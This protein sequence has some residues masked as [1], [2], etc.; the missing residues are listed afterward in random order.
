MEPVMNAAPTGSKAAGGNA[1]AAF[2]VSRAP[3]AAAAEAGVAGARPG[4]D[5]TGRQILRIRAPVQG[6]LGVA[7]YLP[8]RARRA[9][10]VEEPR[11]LLGAEDGLRRP[12]FA[13]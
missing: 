2:G 8:G 7:P 3:V 1:F 9:Q 10:P 4:L 12:V 6:P 13:E 11:L 5:Q